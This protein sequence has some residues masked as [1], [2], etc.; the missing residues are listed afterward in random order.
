MQVRLIKNRYWN[1]N[2]MVKTFVKIYE[3]WNCNIMVKDIN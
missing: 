1:Y 2:I 3:Y